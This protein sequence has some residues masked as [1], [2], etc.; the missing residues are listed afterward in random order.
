VRSGEG[1]TVRF[2]GRAIFVYV[3][4]GEMVGVVWAVDRFKKRMD[5]GVLRG[6]CVSLFVCFCEVFK[7]SGPTKAYPRRPSLCK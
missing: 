1:E 4:V 6:C 3:W 2:G 7:G 5:V